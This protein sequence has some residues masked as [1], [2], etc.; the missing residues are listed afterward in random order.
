MPALRGELEQQRTLAEQRHAE[1][2]AELRT[3]SAAL[4]D[5]FRL[6]Q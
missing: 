2:L 6:P 1:I 3:I 4:K 5:G